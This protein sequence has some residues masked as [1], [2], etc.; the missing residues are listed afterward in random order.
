VNRFQARYSLWLHD[1]GLQLPSL[2]FFFVVSTRRRKFTGR[3]ECFPLSLESNIAKI[4]HHQPPK[5]FIHMLLFEFESPLARFVP[6]FPLDDNIDSTPVASS[7]NLSVQLATSSPDQ[8]IPACSHR[9]HW[10]LP[11][12]ILHLF[13][14]AQNRLRLSRRTEKPFQI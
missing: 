13:Q 12:V 1:V 8:I 10:L 6:W 3:Y 5:L 2:M 11:G 4:S 9:H 7:G 14:S